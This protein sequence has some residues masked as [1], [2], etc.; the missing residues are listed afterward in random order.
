M[1]GRGRASAFLARGL[2]ASE[3][4]K[5]CDSTSASWA[6]RPGRKFRHPLA[7]LSRSTLF[8]RRGAAVPLVSLASLSWRKAPRLTLTGRSRFQTRH[9]LSLK[10]PQ[11]SIVS[12]HRLSLRQLRE[13]VARIEFT[14]RHFG[15]ISG[16]FEL[17]SMHFSIQSRQPG[18]DRCK[19][20]RRPCILP[21]E[22]GISAKIRVTIG[23]K[24]DIQSS[25]RAIM[26]LGRAIMTS[27][28]RVSSS[29]RGT[30]LRGKAKRG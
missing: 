6:R 4:P 8:Q 23:F 1:G 30:S 11:R 9:F 21:R 27:K 28:W 5:C 25:R 29:D 10:L 3:P 22:H 12:G 20:S 24:S 19:I 15:A 13:K 7:T 26:S 17:R 18:L 16:H 2:P 14:S